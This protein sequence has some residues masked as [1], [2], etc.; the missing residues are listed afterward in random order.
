MGTEYLRCFPR[1]ISFLPAW[2]LPAPFFLHC[3]FCW[4]LEALQ[5]AIPSHPL[6]QSLITSPKM[7]F[8][9][10]AILAALAATTDATPT[11]VKF[12]GRD[13]CEAASKLNVT[14]DLRLIIVLV[15]WQNI[16]IGCAIAIAPT[17]VGCVSAAIKAG[18]DP[19]SDAG[20]LVGTTNLVVN[21]VSI[22]KRIWMDTELNLN[23]L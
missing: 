8:S 15:C 12:Y 11:G 6:S 17:A 20:C 7:Q 21:T 18:V 1:S 3:I 14:S 4:E 19:I 9:V 23:H 13:G 16:L 10:V 22:L 5:R 2:R